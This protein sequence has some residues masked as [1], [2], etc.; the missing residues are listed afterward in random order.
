[1]ST[2][3][4]QENVNKKIKQRVKNAMATISN[5]NS[6]EVLNSEIFGELQPKQMLES[7]YISNGILD[8]CI[9]NVFQRMDDEQYA[10][11][12]KPFATKH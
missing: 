6:V 9:D 10:K 4:M 8:F 2:N 3:S 7:I 11:L 1:M 5:T 12:E